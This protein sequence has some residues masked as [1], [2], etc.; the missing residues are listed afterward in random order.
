MTVFLQNVLNKKFN[1]PSTDTITILAGL[2]DIDAIF[3]D[4]VHALDSAM[5]DG[6]T[7]QVKQ[8]AVRTAL[9][10]VAGAYQTGLPSYFINRDLFPSLIQVSGCYVL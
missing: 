8:K 10:A 5:L 4:F 6:R 1:S 3:P 2:D 7:L 9:A